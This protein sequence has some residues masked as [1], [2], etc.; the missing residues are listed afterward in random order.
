MKVQNLEE[1]RHNFE[2]QINFGLTQMI[3]LINYGGPMITAVETFPFEQY[4]SMYFES[5]I[6]QLPA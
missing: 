5:H 6:F 4:G 1:R 3:L 2:D